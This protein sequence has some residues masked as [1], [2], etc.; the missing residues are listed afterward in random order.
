MTQENVRLIEQAAALQSAHDADKLAALYLE[1]AVFEDIP[2]EAVAR[3]HAEMKAF[4]RATW[5][6]MPDFT[7][8][9][10]STVADDRRG[11]A[12]WIMTATHS[13]DFL[14]YPATGKSFSLRAASIAE[15]SNGRIIHWADYW[16]LSTFKEQ[17]GLA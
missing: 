1:D 14:D 15:F 10:V 2:F 16:S 9:L 11:G 3:G 6:S 17:V 13:G 8:K 5:A 4:W 7:M 12:E